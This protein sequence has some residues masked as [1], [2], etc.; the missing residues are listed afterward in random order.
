MG[1]IAQLPLSGNAALAGLS[2][3]LTLIEQISNYPFL[4]RFEVI[5]GTLLRCIELPEVTKISTV[6]L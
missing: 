1:A 6:I 5:N 4:V 3:P 2:K